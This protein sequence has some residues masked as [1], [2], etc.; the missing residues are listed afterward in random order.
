[1]GRILKFLG[2]VLDLFPVPGGPPPLYLF[3]FKK[4]KLDAQILEFFKIGRASS[5]PLQKSVGKLSLAQ[6]LTMGRVAR[7]LLRPLFFQ[8]NWVL[9]C[10]CSFLRL[11]RPV[12][13][14]YRVVSV[15]GP[16]SLIS[17]NSSPDVIIFT[18]AI[19]SGCSWPRGGAPRGSGGRR[20][21][22]CRCPF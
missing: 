20:R 12:E 13:W 15:W 4:D 8:S 21:S 16:R 14:R 17:L 19:L 10:A 18:D 3:R 11:G 2:L 1:M 7:T 5:A 6:T 22:D 9:H